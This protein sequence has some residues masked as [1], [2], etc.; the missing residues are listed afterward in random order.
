MSGHSKWKQIKRQ[1]GVA[2]QKRGQA[3]TKLANA[4]T[5]A[6][7]ASAAAGLSAGDPAQNFRLR[8]TIE[9]ARSSNMPKENITRAIEKG[10]G[11]RGEDI[12]EVVYE[13]FSPGGAAVIVIAATDNKLR[14]TGEVKNFFEKSGGSFGQPGS[15]SYQF[16]NKGVIVVAL[17][18][19][20]VD[21]IFLIAADAGAEDVEQI[22]D[23]VLVYTKPDVLAKIKDVLAAHSLNILEA[24]LIRKPKMNLQID[25]RETAEKI[26][27]FIDKLEDMDDVQK[28]Y[29]NAVIID[30]IEPQI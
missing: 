10:M 13:G 29:T 28:V 21:D 8:L 25:N 26:I 19:H 2:D 11:K 9:K 12:E 23:E 1:K 24:D 27:A 7:H 16:E 17:E 3:F 20:S 15:V 5:I 18:T 4:I 22:G 6:V 14:T 30:T